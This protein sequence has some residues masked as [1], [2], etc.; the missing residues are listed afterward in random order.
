MR[1]VSP[2]IPGE[3]LKEVIV[4]EHQDEYRNLPVAWC[5]NPEQGGLVAL[6]RWHLPPEQREKFLE[7]G[8]IYVFIWTGGKHFNPMLLTTEGPA[9]QMYDDNGEPI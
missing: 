7:T 3:K 9:L 8:D 5:E 2:V 4:A 6:C 1:P